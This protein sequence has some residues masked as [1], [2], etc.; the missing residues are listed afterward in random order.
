[1]AQALVNV[2]VFGNRFIEN[3]YAVNPLQAYLTLRG[4]HNAP[5]I[6]GDYSTSLVAPI[7]QVFAIGSWIYYNNGVNPTVSQR[8][9]T[10][11]GELGGTIPILPENQ[12][13]SRFVAAIRSYILLCNDGQKSLAAPAA[14]FIANNDNQV[15]VQNLLW[16]TVMEHINNPVVVSIVLAGQPAITL[17]STFGL[18]YA[19]ASTEAL[20]LSRTPGGITNLFVNVNVT[21]ALCKRGNF[22]EEFAEKVRTGL[23]NDIG[24]LIDVNPEECAAYYNLYLPELTPISAQNVFAHISPLIPAR[25]IRIRTTIMQAAGSGLTMFNLILAAFNRFPDFD[26]GIIEALFPGQFAAYH[27]ATVAVNGNQYYAFRKTPMG[28]AAS[29]KYNYLAWTARSLFIESGIQR[30]LRAYG[31]PYRNNQYPA[32]A[33]AIRRYLNRDTAIDEEGN[34]LQPNHEYWANTQEYKNDLVGYANYLQQRFEQPEAEIPEV[35]NPGI[36][37]FG[38][39]PIGRAEEN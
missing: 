11:F 24:K 25:A 26:W 4:I 1:M 39:V 14:G 8:N 15:N 32:L 20:R 18:A 22:T 13:R 23:N 35:D 27:A 7:A 9:A 34:I 12:A 37:D 19:Y 6:D 29:T 17:P 10:V 36:P 21:V 5:F 16:N 2:P 3:A 31:A 28:D 38:D 30:H 33:Q